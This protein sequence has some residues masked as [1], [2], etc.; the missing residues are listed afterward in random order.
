MLVKQEQKSPCEVE[1]HIKVDAEKVDAAVDDAYA[2]LGKAANIPGFRKGKAP[3]VV[4]ERVLDQE[5]VKDRAADKLLKSAY[6]E[7]LEESKLE[8]YA[9]ADV[10]IIKFEL[11]EPL[12]FKAVVPL[13]PKV[14]LGDYKGIDVERKVEPVTDEGIEENIKGIL[15]RHTQFPEV[16]EREARVGDV[17]RVEMKDDSD[18]NAEMKSNVFDIGDALPE[19]NNGLA[20]MNP[21]DEKVIGVTYPDDFQAEELRGKTIPWRVKMC[22]IHEKKVPELSDE[23]VKA[24][25][26]PAPKEGEEPDSEQIDTVEKFRAKIKSAMQESEEHAADAEVRNKIVD[27]VIENAKADFPGVLVS[28]NVQ[29]HMEELAKNLKKRNL[30]IDDFLKYRDIKFEDL[31]SEYEESAKKELKSSIVL[32]E[33]VTKED[34]KIEDSDVEEALQVMADENRVPVETIRA[35]VDKTKSMP[36]VRNRILTK[37]VIDFLVNASNIKNVE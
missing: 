6:I 19:F 35:Y 2:E 36:D 11:G 29:K 24:N 21:D 5:R 33:I 16:H 15:E 20:G 37:K 31:Q 4:L 13:E 17:V 1:L 18:P 25:F 14:E 3:R 34:I 7:A 8:P 10:D 9:L 23:W 32:G 27:K 22:E 28:D 30:T 12:E 26:A